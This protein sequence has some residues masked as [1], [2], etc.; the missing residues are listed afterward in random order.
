LDKFEFNS[1]FEILYWK[2]ERNQFESCPSDF[3]ISTFNSE[4]PEFEIRFK[5]NLAQIRTQS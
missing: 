1:K 2:S 4:H 3:C 5:P